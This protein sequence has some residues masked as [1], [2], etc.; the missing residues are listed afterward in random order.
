[1]DG[2]VYLLGALNTQ[3]DMTMVVP[4]GYKCLQLGSLA[5]PTLLLHG[6]DLQNLILE[7]CPQ[8][9]INNLRLLEGLKQLLELP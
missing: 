7:R 5:S 9:E 6:H 2:G 1:L 4:N 8:K 3:T